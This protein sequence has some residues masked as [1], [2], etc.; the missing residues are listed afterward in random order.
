MVSCPDVFHKPIYLGVASA[1]PP[2]MPS[3]CGRAL[4]QTPSGGDGSDI[5]ERIRTILPENPHI[6]SHNSQRGYIRC[7]ATPQ[8]LQADFRVLPY[9]SKPDAPVSTRASFVIEDGRA[10]A[11]SA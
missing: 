1:D 7:A 6:H 8:H 9:V 4:P 10:G 5:P 11:Q 2:T 3:S